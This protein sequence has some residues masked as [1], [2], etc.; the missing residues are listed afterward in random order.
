LCSRQEGTISVEF[1]ILFPLLA[2]IV[3][4]LMEFG[5]LWFVRHTLTNAS[6]E[7][8]RAAVVF[9]S[10]NMQGEARETWAQNTAQSTVDTYLKNIKFPSKWTVKTETSGSWNTGDPVTVTVSTPNGLMLLD[11]FIPAFHGITV[12][13]MTTMKME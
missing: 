6:R 3:V 12:S 2:L 9:L 10:E 5:Y 13:G 1:V 8:A 4:G 11:K 7:G